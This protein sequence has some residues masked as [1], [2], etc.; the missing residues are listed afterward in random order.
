MVCLSAS[1]SHHNVGAFL[2]H[3]KGLFTESHSGTLRNMVDTANILC[4]FLCLLYGLKA[5]SC[6][7]KFTL[8]WLS[9]YHKLVVLLRTVS[10]TT[11]RRGM[12]SKHRCYQTNTRLIH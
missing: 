6:S 5:L 8:K 12:V 4:C 1:I 9:F 7:L 11:Q 2:I 10:L 3:T